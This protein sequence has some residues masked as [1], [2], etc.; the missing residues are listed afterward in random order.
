MFRMR[1]VF[2]PFFTYF[3]SISLKQ[4]HAID[5][6]KVAQWPESKINILVLFAIF[7]INASET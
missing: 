5:I 2:L 7:L 6:N 1:G 4:N 3:V